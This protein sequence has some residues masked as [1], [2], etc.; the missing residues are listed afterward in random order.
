[1]TWQGLSTACGPAQN[2]T[3]IRALSEGTDLQVLTSQGSWKRLVDRHK[4][5]VQ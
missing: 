3:L 2:S 5:Q 1:M 4:P